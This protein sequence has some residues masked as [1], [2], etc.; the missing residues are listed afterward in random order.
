MTYHFCFCGI[1]IFMFT[2]KGPYKLL[3]W[4]VFLMISTNQIWHFV[5]C[6]TGKTWEFSVPYNT[7][8]GQIWLVGNVNLQWHYYL[9]VNNA[10]WVQTCWFDS[11]FDNFNKSNWRF[12]LWWTSETW[13][14]PEPY[15]IDK[16][17]FWLFGIVN[18][19]LQKFSKHQ[20]CGSTS[21]INI[22]STYQI[23]TLYC[24]EPVKP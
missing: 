12:V 1:I 20:T 5:L 19:R 18:W 15:I 4:P 22:I 17:Q 14:W 6:W 23:D 3:D 8:K 9:H 24:A 2:I 7:D 10:R 11:L 16:G 13:E 21:L